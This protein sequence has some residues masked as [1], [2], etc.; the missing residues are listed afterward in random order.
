M[1]I[2]EQIINVYEKIDLYI[3]CRNYLVP[4]FL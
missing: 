4:L 3:N 2:K 1:T